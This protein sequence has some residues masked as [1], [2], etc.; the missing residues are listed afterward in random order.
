MKK[1]DAKVLLKRYIEGVASDEEKLFVEKSILEFN[2][3]YM[4]LSQDR[5]DEI[6]EE[7]YAKLSVHREKKIKLYIWTSVAAA[8]LVII[9]AV[10][11]WELE[12]NL[13]LMA[14]TEV[15]EDIAPIGNR[16]ILMVGD[17]VLTL[18]GGKQGLNVSRDGVQY[19]DGSVVDNNITSQLSQTLSTPRGGQY[20]VVLSDGTKVWLNAASSISYPSSFDGAKERR[21][22]VTGEVYFEVAKDRAKPFVVASRGQSIRV[23]GTHFNVNAYGDYGTTATTLLEGSVSVSLVDNDGGAKI[24]KPMQQ[25]IAG[26]GRTVIRTA[27]VELAMA[28]KNGVFEFKDASLKSILNEVAR[29]YDL[30]VEYRGEVPDRVF[31]GSV[32]RKSNLSVLLKILSY[33]D[34]KFRI[35]TD[36]ATTKKLIVEP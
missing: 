33:S 6:K 11:H 20:R 23:L 18:N 17:K 9:L 5:I 22:S 14:K 28:W 21:V 2:E 25:L 24:L 16:A 27:D 32:S 34:I 31:N 4:E 26:N 8:V 1:E 29:W 36:G 3:D 12:E 30:D 10:T 13:Q 19:L 7:V 15:I 35:E